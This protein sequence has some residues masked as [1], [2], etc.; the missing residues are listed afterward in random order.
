MVKRAAFHGSPFACP[1]LA[2]FLLSKYLSIYAYR[3]AFV[4]RQAHAIRLAY[5]P[6]IIEPGGPKTGGMQGGK[7]ALVGRVLGPQSLGKPR[8]MAHR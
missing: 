7:R 8:E 2:R 6:P 5:N 1:R 4:S 3:K